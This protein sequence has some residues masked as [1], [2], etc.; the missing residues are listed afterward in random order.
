MF[1]S[2]SDCHGENILHHVLAPRTGKNMASFSVCGGLRR[3]SLVLCYAISPSLH[4]AS[5]EMTLAVSFLGRCRHQ[6][7]V[8]HRAPQHSAY[9][10][11][12]RP[13][14]RGVVES[15]IVRS[16]V[17]TGMVPKV[18]HKRSPWAVASESILGSCTSMRDPD[19]PTL[20]RRSHSLRQIYRS[21]IVVVG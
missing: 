16:Q 20:E 13:D 12:V 6:V 1:V 18:L 9:T 7:S 5:K 17:V 11:H 21:W 15:A 8:H 19:I 3:V 14:A 2:Y 4:L 10:A